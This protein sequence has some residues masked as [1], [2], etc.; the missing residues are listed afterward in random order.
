M[1]KRIGRVFLVFLL[2]IGGF[3]VLLPPAHT[4]EAAEEVKLYLGETKAIPVTNPTRVVI[5]NPSVADVMSVSK[6]EVTVSPKAA[7]ATNLLIWDNFGEQ[8]YKLKVFSE[9]INEVRRRIDNLLGKLNLPAVHTQ[10]A[11]EEGKVLLLGAVKSQQEKDKISLVL[12][13]FKDKTIDLIAIKEEEAVVEIDVQVLELDKDATQTLGFTWPSAINIME[14]GS[15][16]L[17][18]TSWGK[19]FRILNVKRATSAATDP[20]TLKLD[21]LIQ[22]GKARILSR[23]RLACQ[24]GKEAEL[25]VGGEKPIFTT[26]VASA[27]GQ[28]SQVEYKEYGIKLKI[29]PTV[30]DDERIRLGLNVEV[31]E[32][33]TAETLGSS[34]NTTAKAYPLTRRNASTELYL[35]DGQAMAIGGLIKQKSEED[36][37]R[38]PW[39]SNIPVLGA[40][41]RQKVLKT[42]G[43]QG[44]KGNTELFII[45]TPKI[46]SERKNAAGGKK[47]EGQQP[48]PETGKGG[49]VSPEAAYANLVQKRIVE[50]INYPAVA[51]ASGF[52][53]TVTLSLLLSYQG[54][55]L[56][57]KIKN[58]SGYKILDDSAIEAA[59]GIASYPPF[60]PEIEAKELKVE[61]PLVY[62]L[63]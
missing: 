24:S 22:E 13:G 37:R 59:S 33:G 5:N 2:G 36:V 31:S 53:G 14:T 18:G 48:A 11:E 57:V 58:S 16:G 9:D 44:E 60:P 38:V 47:I 35:D 26:Q 21:M 51:R 3:L 41:F 20:F 6:S 54:E 40:I 19:L 55:L 23:P 29:R 32:V 7:G 50:K 56:D 25:L 15:P 52:Q 45:L 4:R 39:V 28:G 34:T 10:P 1:R 61:M 49:A 43:G 17:A 42:G 12:G 30:T 46:V 27:G 63:E 62:R 8:S